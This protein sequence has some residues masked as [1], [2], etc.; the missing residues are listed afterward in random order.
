ME[1]VSHVVVFLVPAKDFGHL[2]GAMCD[3]YDLSHPDVIQIDVLELS[4][5]AVTHGQSH[6]VALTIVGEDG[7][8]VELHP[9]TTP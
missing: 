9:S 4:L 7:C 8:V 1:Y 6:Q 2:E 5:V 3:G